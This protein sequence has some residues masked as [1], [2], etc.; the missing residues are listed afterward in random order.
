MNGFQHRDDQR[1]FE[2]LLC[3]AGED[4]SLYADLFD[5]RSPGEKRKEFIRSR[6]AI[7]SAL[8]NRFGKSCMLQFA[9]DCDVAS[10][11]SLDHLI[12]LSS[13]KLNRVLRNVGTS[14]TLEGRLKKA[15]SQSFGSNGPRNVV[16]ACN[17]CNSFKKHKLLDRSAIKRVLSLLSEP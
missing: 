11:I 4:L 10:G 7:L 14:R 8:E 9:P 17:N 3:E 16:L 6:A 2:D 13:N 12:P 1:F 5:F 15:P